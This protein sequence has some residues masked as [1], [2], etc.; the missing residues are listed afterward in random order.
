MLHFMNANG[1][2]RV[3]LIALFAVSSLSLTACKSETN[4][5]A[6]ENSSDGGD[7]GTG[8]TPTTAT[9][10][11]IRVKAKTGV[12]AFI[13]RFGDITAGCEIT[14][15]EKDTPTARR[16]MLNMMEYDL[17]YHGFSYEL[18]V[19]PQFCEY[20]EEQ[21]YYYWESMAGVPPATATISALD[22]VIT[23]CNADGVAG[24]IAPGGASCTV[25]EGVFTAA[26]GFRCDYD[27]TAP[28]SLGRNCCQGTTQLSLTTRTTSGNPPV[29]SSVTSSLR[30]E[31]SGRLANC[32]TSPHTYIDNW[33]KSATTGLAIDS[34]L[35]LG[36]NQFTRVQ[37]IPSAFKVFNEAK[38][39]STSAVVFNAGMHDWN[40][41]AISPA[42]WGTARQVPRPLRPIRDRGPNG[43]WSPV[44]ALDTNLLEFDG[45]YEFRCIGPAG[46]IKH[47]L[48][49]YVNEWNTTEDF[50]A[51][52]TNG[53]AT[54]VDPSRQGLAGVDCS[55]VNLGQ[56]CNTFWGFQDI[57]LVDAGGDATLWYFPDEWRR[58]DPN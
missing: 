58:G 18:N 23:I 21:P 43:N 30:I 33:P 10:M 49:L 28:G 32:I 5:F 31:Q 46:E 15:A 17:W 19:P 44:G 1:R 2:I 37:Q 8:D 13:H 14:I 34:V 56:T 20:V 50:E 35:E 51:F 26:G 54:A 57:I 39:Y 48:R 16:C 42:G 9:G 6:A 47:R 25:G 41:Y 52:K 3:L 55:A 7:G 53:I 12:A 4:V 11:R 29:V 38:R 36:G 24:A 40:Q 45:S 22:G 27:Y